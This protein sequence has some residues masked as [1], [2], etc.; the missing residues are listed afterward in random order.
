MR[1]TGELGKAMAHMSAVFIAVAPPATGEGEAGM[2]Y[3]DE[4]SRAVAASLTAT[5]V[6]VEKSTIPVFTHDLVAR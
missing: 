2:S 3:V 4:V 1:F 5:K 6:V